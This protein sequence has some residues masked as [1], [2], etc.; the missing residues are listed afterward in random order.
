MKFSFSI[1]SIW[2]LIILSLSGLFS[3]ISLFYYLDPLTYIKIPS[4][5]DIIYYKA[6]KKLF[7]GFSL[8]SL[9]F[10]LTTLFN[11]GKF[12]KKISQ[13]SNRRK[14]PTIRIF[15]I[16]SVCCSV[17]YPLGIV[18]IIQ[19]DPTTNRNLY[20]ICMLSF[21]LS[22]SILHLLS[23]GILAISSNRIVKLSFISVITLFVFLSLHFFTLFIDFMHPS[24]YIRSLS[25][26]LQ[27]MSIIFND[28]CFIFT[29]LVVFG[30]RFIS[31]SM[32]KKE[33][34]RV[35]SQFEQV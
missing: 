6:P 12:F 13:N 28:I 7:R 5:R 31:N 1:I 25:N 18:G 8:F 22:P 23:Q 14:S 21:L 32:F 11:I 26:S 9:P 34:Q 35:F 20:D 30:A 17:L 2:L 29:G 4:I 33:N 27:L 3:S 24:I 10:L 16:V 15:F 19:I